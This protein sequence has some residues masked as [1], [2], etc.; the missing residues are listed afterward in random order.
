[1]ADSP[2]PLLVLPAA[3]ALAQTRAAGTALRAAAAGRPAAFTVQAADRFG[4]PCD[5]LE[6]AELEA[7]QVI[8][9]RLLF[10]GGGGLGGGADELRVECGVRPGGR[11]ECEYTA[12][13]PGLYVLEVTTAAAAP[14]PG[15]SAAGGACWRHV[16]GSPFGLRVAGGD[17]GGSRAEPGE[18]DA[19]GSGE[20]AGAAGVRDVVGWWGEVA[21]RVYEAVDGCA[22]GFGEADGEAQG[23]TRPAGPEAAFV[24][25]GLWFRGWA[26]SL[27]VLELNA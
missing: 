14:Q 23:Q 27:G 19:G 21:R 9:A 1:V 22:E 4:N 13:A 16:Q 3:P 5:H 17:G 12:G 25:V 11:W 6:A 20:G 15:A 26:G 10:T 7:A 18:C 8:Q 2:Y 24:A